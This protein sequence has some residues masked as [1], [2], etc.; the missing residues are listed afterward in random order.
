MTTYRDSGEFRGA[1]FVDVD[2]TGARF[3]EVDL[4][5]ARMRGVVL[6]GVD[7]DGYIDDLVIN[8]VD[9]VPLIEA[10]LD[11]RHPERVKLR[12]TTPA[13]MREA[14]DA[15]ESFWA[16]TMDRA[17]RLGEA[18]LHRSVD[19]EWSFAQ[20]LRHLVFVTD[21]WLGHAVL[22]QAHPFH[23][24]GLPAS[25]SDDGSEFGIDVGADPPFDHIL[26]ARTDRMA[27]VRAFVDSVT[28]NDLDRDRESNSAAGWPPP[29][30]RSAASCLRVI[31]NEEWVH[32]RFAVRDLAIVEAGS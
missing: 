23:P 32:H 14:W 22:G 26:A 18:D 4:S 28:Q 2:M 10:E 25:V 3:R 15:V 24:I 6:A 1:E 13:G 17:G 8:G 27:R 31:F 12:S 29:A 7:I 20:T 9:V 21:A 5:G 19:D 30:S 16:A 11:R